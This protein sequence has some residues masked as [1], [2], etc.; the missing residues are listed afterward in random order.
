M[1]G[2]YTV[3]MSPFQAALLNR[4]IIMLTA[5]VVAVSLC[6]MAGWLT[7]N[8]HLLL[9]SG[10]E[11]SPMKFNTGL[12]LILCAI[13]IALYR[14]KRRLIIL[15][16]A[17]LA[18]VIA[19][20]TGLE[21]FA[22]LDLGIDNLFAKPFVETHGI[23]TGRMGVYSNIDLFL[24]SLT[25][26]YYGLARDKRYFHPVIMALGGSLAFLWASYLYLVMPAD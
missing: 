23:V 5:I 25:L 12:G 11:Y 24:T 6:V 13:S 20:L 2:V 22:H 16:P 14:Q 18:F 3:K 9:R 19:V 15:I 4:I 7:G 21:N 17:F 1:T 8:A 10:P 26:L